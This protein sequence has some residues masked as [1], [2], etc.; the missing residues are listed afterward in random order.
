MPALSSL[1]LVGSYKAHLQEKELDYKKCV[2]S[3]QGVL[4]QVVWLCLYHI[5]SKKS[6][7]DELSHGLH[8][9]VFTQFAKEP[10]L[11][12]LR[13]GWF[14]LHAPALSGAALRWSCPPVFL[15][16]CQQR[17]AQ[18]AEGQLGKDL[19]AHKHILLCGFLVSVMIIHDV[20]CGCARTG[21]LHLQ[22]NMFLA[23]ALSSRE[24]SSC[25]RQACC[26]D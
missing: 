5:K 26:P 13:A 21:S 17:S 24:F 7:S 12:C 11:A 18:M 14:R 22:S 4:P 10:V 19:R 9:T 20:I 15:S 1:N 16:S 23:L 8:E 25:T 3:S 2:S 6:E